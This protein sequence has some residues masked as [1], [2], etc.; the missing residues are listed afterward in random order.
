[1]SGLGAG[2][3]GEGVVELDFLDCDRGLL[4]KG[5]S[6]GDCLNS[7]MSSTADESVARYGCPLGNTEI[8]GLIFKGRSVFA[9]SSEFEV[10]RISKL[11]R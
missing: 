1:M 11:D 5:S 9:H 10:Q 3:A 6:S 7:M 8:S 2:V 4:T